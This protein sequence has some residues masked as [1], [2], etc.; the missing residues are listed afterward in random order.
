MLQLAT[1]RERIEELCAVRHLVAGEAWVE[2]TL[3]L[4][5]IQQLRHGVMMV[6]PTSSGKTTSWRTLLEA[7]TAV[8]GVKGDVYVIDPKAINKEML[9]GSQ[10][11]W[12]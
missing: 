1:L 4:Y 8:D 5:Q 6:G 3:Q 10:G 2:K 11:V 12:S 7:M 9:Y